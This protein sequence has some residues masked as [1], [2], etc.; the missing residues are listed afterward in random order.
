VICETLNILSAYPMTK[1]GYHSADATHVTIEALRRA[2]HDRN[3]LLGDPDYVKMDLGKLTSSAYAD[4]LR[5]GIAMNSDR[6]ARRRD[7]K[8]RRT[9]HHAFLDRRSGRQC[10]LGH[11]YAQRLVRGRVTAPGTG[12]LMN[13]EMDDFSAKPGA[14]NIYGLVG[15]PT[16]RSRRASA[17]CPR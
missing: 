5:A 14:S 3:L 7:G 13:D 6:L 11:L 10:G 9:E 17:R 1:M 8:P 15:G 4:T 2:Y 12:I 16:T